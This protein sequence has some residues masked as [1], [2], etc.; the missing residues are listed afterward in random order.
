MSGSVDPFYVIDSKLKIA[1]NVKSSV[2]S[3]QIM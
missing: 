2:G 3:L 1:R